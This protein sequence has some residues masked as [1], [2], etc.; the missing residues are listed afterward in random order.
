SPPTA[1]TRFMRGIILRRSART[2]SAVPSGS[3]G[4]S[5]IRQLARGGLAISAV[6]IWGAACSAASGIVLARGLGPAGR[7]EFAVLWTVASFG[8]LLGGCCLPPGVTYY[9]ASERGAIWVK[10]LVVVQP[11]LR[12]R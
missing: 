3:I 10:R 2:G 6:R 1:K 4:P 11:T 5:R 9:A 8:V 12:V 7:G